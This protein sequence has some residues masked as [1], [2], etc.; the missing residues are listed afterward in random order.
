MRDIRQVN[1]PYREG[2]I[3][4][5]CSIFGAMNTAGGRF[6]GEGVI[7][8]IANMHDRGNGQGGGFAI[9]GLY[10]DYPEQYAFHIMF[11][12]EKGQRETEAF[13]RDN[14]NLML[15]TITFQ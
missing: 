6:S 13:L 4:D 14:F 5:A 8:A 11:L 10:P 1:N 3:I 9:Y 2:K 12:S 7:K 15:G